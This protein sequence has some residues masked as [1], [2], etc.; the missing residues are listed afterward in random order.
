MEDLVEKLR[1]TKVFDKEREIIA[2]E[3]LDSKLGELYHLL[4]LQLFSYAYHLL[5]VCSHNV[6]VTAGL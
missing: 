2:Y 1:I 4:A 5:S 6:A 3:Q